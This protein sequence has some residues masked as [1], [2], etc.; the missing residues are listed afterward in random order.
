MI[1]TYNIFEGCSK[2]K[3]LAATEVGSYRYEGENDIDQM[4]FTRGIGLN[5]Q[6]KKHQKLANKLNTE[7]NRIKKKI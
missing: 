2:S 7:K 4:R 3:P 5:A 6:S 1:S